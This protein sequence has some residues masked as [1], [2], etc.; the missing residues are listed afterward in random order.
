MIFLLSP[1][2]SGQTTFPY[3]VRNLAG[4]F[5]LGDGGPATSALLYYPTAA[6]PDGNGNLYILDSS[7][8][9]IRKVASD[10]KISTLANVSGNDMKLGPDGN[11]YVAGNA[12]VYRVSLNGVLTPIA[13][14]GVSGYSGDNGP[15]TSA[16]IGS[17][18]GVAI[19]VSGSIFFTEQTSSGHHIRQIAPDGTIK[20]IAGT[21]NVGYGGD[22]G[23]ATAATLNY[24]IGIA[25]DSS[26]SIYVADRNSHRVRQISGGRIFSVIGTGSS[27][28]PID[29]APAT[30]PLGE[31]F[32]LAIDAGD[33][34]YV[35]DTL[36]HVVLKSTPLGRLS[37]VAGSYVG[38]GAAG[39]GRATAVTLLA[40]CSISIDKSGNLYIADGAHL[41]RKITTGGDAVTVA[42]RL[43]YAGDGGP[44]AAALLNEPNGVAV[45]LQGNTYIADSGNYVFRKISSTGTITTWAGNGVPGGVVDGANVSSVQLPYVTALASDGKG[46]LYF[47][48]SMQAF[49][50]T[51]TG[52][53]SVIA[54]AGSTGDTGDG[55]KATAAT[56]KNI[57]GIAADSFG[58]VYLADIDSNRVR[59][60]SAD[61]IVTAFAGTGSRGKVA[62]GGLA[63][64]AQLSLAAPVKPL[65]TVPMVI[66]P[67]GNLYF[68]DMGNNSVLMV[69]GAG[70]L[71]VVAGIGTFGRAVDGARA[72]ASQLTAASGLAVDSAGDL[73]MSTF[74]YGDLFKISGGMLHRLNG[75]GAANDGAALSASYF[76]TR[77]LAID[78]A[79]DLYSVGTGENTV[80][81]IILNSPIA[82][83]V[84]DGDR[85]A[86]PAGQSLP[87]PLRVQLNGRAGAGISG[88]PVQFAV[89]SG[90]AGLSAT[91][92]TTDATGAAAVSVKLGASAGPVT[93]TAT[94][95]G[96]NLAPVQFNLT[97]TP[98][99]SGSCSLTPPVVKSAATAEDFGKSAAFSAG[100]WLE[101]KGAN[102]ASG[103]R[104]W[105]G[106]DFVDGRAPTKLDGV[107]VTIN[108][109]PAFIR[110]ISPG[111]INVQA[112]AD[113]TVGPVDV[114]VTTGN[115][116]SAAFVA[117][118]AGLAPG[119][120]APVLFRSG[121]KQYLAAV[122]PDGWFVGTADLVPGAPL[123][124]VAPGET[125]TLYGVGFGDVTPAVDPGTPA[126]GIAGL[127]G[128]TITFATTVAK[129]SYAGMAP[130]AIGL[131]QFNVTVPDLVDGDYAIELKAGAVTASPQSAYLTVRR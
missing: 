72:T 95:S 64:S 127:A 42:G 86:A 103:S 6:V 52:I 96:T 13:G 122:L 84:V 94:A 87:K 90:T 46:N 50:I 123:R 60:V 107:G 37:R 102:L 56:F 81:K 16:Q 88:M 32:A 69:D 73:Y 118:K 58:N 78:A 21:L 43:H 7:N 26:G 22:G 5:P 111:Q 38:W 63:T 11:L 115:C 31:P 106:A 116:Q 83:E 79:G 49:K 14:T 85:Q 130:G 20:T 76:F 125:I 10:G 131:Y 27:G 77:E 101:I 82:L 113:T 19:D 120:L 30:S 114:V 18:M 112:P 45:D 91:T 28:R 92:T 75:S 67:R 98:A 70:I 66:D 9:R 62:S 15:A 47:T 128:V 2:L 108:G 109:R 100:S 105:T 104:E 53:V 59:K 99:G 61:G 65:T 25:I 17:A 119:L 3:I 33:N 36:N 44:A 1:S 24:P 29:G 23:L 8:N 55:G 54:G 80:R 4:A 34:L 39:D 124:P 41:V 110:Y 57:A 35:S 51:P 40:P 126:T 129:V 68:G 93:V 121:G 97:A 89:T 12:W 48:S 71:S 117:Q 74:N